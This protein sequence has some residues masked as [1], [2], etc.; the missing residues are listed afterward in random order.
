MALTDYSL[1]QYSKIP[2]VSQETLDALSKLP[3]YSEMANLETLPQNIQQ[4]AQGITPFN[5]VEAQNIQKASMP[6]IQT[7]EPQLETGDQKDEYVKMLESG[8]LKDMQALDELYKMRSQAALSGYEQG[9]REAGVAAGAISKL[10]TIAEEQ[11]KTVDFQN[12]QL[13]KHIQS[14]DEIKRQYEGMK[15]DSG[16]LWGKMGTGQKIM[17]SLALVI[18]GIGSGLTGK[19]NSALQ[20]MNNAIDRDI[21]DQRDQITIQGKKYEAARGVYSDMLNKFGNERAAM[22][23][24]KDLYLQKAQLELNKYALKTNS[25]EARQKAMDASAQLEQQRI[26]MNMQFK[27]SMLNELK[28]K[29]TGDIARGI[30]TIQDEKEREQATEEYGRLQ[31]MKSKEQQVDTIFSDFARIKEEKSYLTSP[32]EKTRQKEMNKTAVRLLLA[33]VAQKFPKGG[34]QV[35]KIVDSLTPSK[36]DTPE[37]IALKK[38]RLI[39]TIKTADDKGFPTLTKRGLLKEQ[40]QIQTGRPVK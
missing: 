16:R 29:G 12:E 24:T 14:A 6:M 37:T 3:K 38:K 28:A 23:M 15:V 40:K 25:I 39:E 32:L 34:E 13:D 11:Q 30:D 20:I 17:A 18:G 33:D 8:K 10:G 31:S 19:E 4:T 27:A 22:A 35:D 2:N 9:D 7:E 36:G 5:P 1:D 26:M 21:Q